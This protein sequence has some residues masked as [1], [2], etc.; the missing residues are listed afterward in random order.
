MVLQARQGRDSA[1]CQQATHRLGG[2]GDHADRHE[3]AGDPGRAG[4]SRRAVPRT[5]GAARAS[6][7][8]GEK[9]RFELNVESGKGSL[10]RVSYLKS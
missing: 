1:S 6:N 9:T 5:N 2:G 4:S 10:N 7:A 8:L 3:P